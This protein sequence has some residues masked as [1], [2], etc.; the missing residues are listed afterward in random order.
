MTFRT[1]LFWVH[2]AA[3]VVAGLVILVM[4]ITGVALTYERQMGQ[5]A[6]R[7]LRSA[8]PTA[9]ARRVTVEEVLET[10][11]QSHPGVAPTAITMG[12]APD[13]P[14]VVASRPEPLYL[15]AYSGRPLGER[16]DGGLRGFLSEMRSWHRWLAIT[17]ESRPIAR[18]ITGWSNLLFLFIVVSGMYLWLPR[19][20]TRAQ[21]K[22]V[23]LF[24]RAYGTSK[25]RD[26]N[27]HNVIGIW[28]SIP[29]FIVV[30]TAVPISF[31]WASDLVYRAV[32]EAPPP[33]GGRGGPAGNANAAR[34][35][36]GSG[37]EA[38]PN[39]PQGRA[40]G[41][42]REA[43]GATAEGPAN[44][45]QRG[46]GRRRGET[47]QRAET[48]LDVTGLDALWARA[49]TEQP[50]W[51]TL[52]LRLPDAAGDPLVFSIDRGDGGQPHL[53]S[54]LTLSRSGDVVAS[55]TFADLSR[56]RQIRNVMRFAHTGE[57]LGIAGQTVAGLVSAGAVVMVWTG[58]A[59]TWRRYRTWRGRRGKPADAVAPARAAQPQMPPR[60]AAARVPTFVTQAASEPTGEP[61]P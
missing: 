33:R 46:D 56:G 10:V 2:L 49:A 61:A 12:S 4:S 34:A 39:P 45:A 29:L 17:G 44:R 54:T 59:L 20:W 57:V 36:R 37:G 5:W 26:F 41:A 7:Q 1:V 14:V 52:S 24:R 15:D 6:D 9:D 38:R 58:L 27:W 16:S 22:S 11:G 60:A 53:R 25:A 19:V 35:Q 18:A 32:G 50:G 13:A 21:V 8:P 31:P 51:R 28:S 55:E 40:A 47:Q 30:L 48:P 43:G 42:P 3:G 23:L